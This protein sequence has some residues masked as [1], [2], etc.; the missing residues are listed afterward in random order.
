MDGARW[1]ERRQRVHR[2]PDG[3]LVHNAGLFTHSGRARSAVYNELQRV[4]RNQDSVYVQ[5]DG[6]AGLSVCWSFGDSLEP[7]GWPDAR[8]A[9]IR[10]LLPHMRHCARVPPRSCPG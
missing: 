7:A 8:V 9:F 4:T 1:D 6:P 5:F 2:L 3:V 10:R